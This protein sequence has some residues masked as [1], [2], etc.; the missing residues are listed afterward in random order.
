MKFLLW[1]LGVMLI[2]LGLEG[3]GNSPGGWTAVWISTAVLW[4]LVGLVAAGTAVAKLVAAKVRAGAIPGLG[5][6]RPSAPAPK[7]ED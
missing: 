4:F 6:R 5:G 3:R 1:L 7:Q 2:L